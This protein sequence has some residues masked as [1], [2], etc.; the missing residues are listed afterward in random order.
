M[1][2]KHVYSTHDTLVEH[3]FCKHI[4]PENYRGIKWN[5]NNATIKLKCHI[6][7]RFHELCRF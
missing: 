4:Y 1:R 5:E 6:N 3:Y 7:Y 2:N